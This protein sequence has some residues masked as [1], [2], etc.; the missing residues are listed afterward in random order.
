MLPKAIRVLVVLAFITSISS[1]LQAQSPT[2]ADVMRDRISKAKAQ[3]VV[4]NYAAA[5]YDLENIR[6]ETNDRT[7]HRVLNILLMHAY[8]EQGDYKR[9]QKF[10]GEL[11]KSKKPTA[12]ED[13]LA[14]AGQVVSGARTQ[15]KRYQV[16]GLE[17][18]DEYL[19]GYAVE[20]LNQMRKTLELIITQSKEL[21]KNKRLAPNALALLEETSNGIDEV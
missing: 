1:T 14:I 11:Y 17:V 10:L 3:L 8:L 20:D 15:L 19:P 13:Y 9:T 2:S 5:I 7:I 16:L 6:R 21:S 4:K 12:G 18:S